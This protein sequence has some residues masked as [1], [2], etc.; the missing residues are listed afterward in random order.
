MALFMANGDWDTPLSKNNSSSLMPA[1]ASVR[2]SEASRSKHT[3]DTKSKEDSGWEEDDFDPQTLIGTVITY[4]DP[5]TGA[6]VQL[7]LAKLLGSGSFALVYSADSLGSDYYDS[8]FNAH[9]PLSPA[10][11]ILAVKCLFKQGLS[12]A[13]LALQRREAELLTRLADHEGII[14]LHAV[15]EMPSFLFLIMDRCDE[16]MFDAILTGKLCGKGPFYEIEDEME[17][18]DAIKDIFAQMVSAVS[19]CHSRGIY[20]RDLKVSRLSFICFLY[21]AFQ[22]SNQVIFLVPFKFNAL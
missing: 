21:I 12:S 1:T 2:Y 22:F 11:S 18:V 7:T 8:S 4:Q 6:N 3:F 5:A 16:D 20:H 17:M 10:P 9:A 13:Q 19:F 14:R 15:S